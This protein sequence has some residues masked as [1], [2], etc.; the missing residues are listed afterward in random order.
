MDNR[1][2][3]PQGCRHQGRHPWWRHPQRLP[4]E[5]APESTRTMSEDLQ[6]KYRRRLQSLVA[7][8]HPMLTSQQ[9]EIVEDLVNHGEGPE[10]MLMLAWILVE[11]DKR[12]PASTIAEI[13]ELADDLIDPN[14]FPPN[15]DQCA[16]ERS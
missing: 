1:G 7:R 2:G 10:A 3:N 12:V 6:R 4:D 11:G 15:L 14:E 5:P 9:R 8:L 16:I 13:R